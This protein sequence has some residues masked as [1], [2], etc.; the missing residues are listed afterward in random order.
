MGLLCLTPL[1]RF[2]LF[3]RRVPVSGP[4]PGMENMDKSRFTDPLSLT[5][6]DSQARVKRKTARIPFEE[7][8]MKD[9]E[10]RSDLPL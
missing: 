7:V 5:A 9:A 8:R 2:F 1:V 10:T 3:R 6:Q 4:L